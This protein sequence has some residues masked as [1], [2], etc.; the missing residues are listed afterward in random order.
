MTHILHYFTHQ[1]KACEISI[2][3]ITGRAEVEGKLQALL[4]SHQNIPGKQ[5]PT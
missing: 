3:Q 5:L 1:E 4:S 2:Y